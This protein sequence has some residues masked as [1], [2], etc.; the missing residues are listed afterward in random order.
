MGFDELEDGWR[1]ELGPKPDEPV[2]A[3]RTLS[4]SGYAKDDKIS[5]WGKINGLDS[6]VSK[7]KAAELKSFVDSTRA[8]I[9][10]AGDPSD[11]FRQDVFSVDKFLS[12]TSLLVIK[13]SHCLLYG[14][15]PPELFLHRIIGL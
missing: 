11:I 14:N 5:V 15:S 2:F 9:A 8:L 13:Q 6:S 1:K 7:E 3:R 4:L 12:D 10:H